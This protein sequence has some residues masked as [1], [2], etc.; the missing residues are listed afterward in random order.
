MWDGATNALGSAARETL[1]QAELGLF[2]NL[3]A[4]AV[5]DDFTHLM[6]LDARALSCVK[7]FDDGCHDPFVRRRRLSVTSKMSGKER[8]LLSSVF[9]SPL[10]AITASLEPRFFVAASATR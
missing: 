3:L 9:P 8:L 4:A 7:S 10:A 6:L 2:G 1:H 5:G